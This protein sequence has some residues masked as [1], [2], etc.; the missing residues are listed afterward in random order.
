MSESLFLYFDSK[1]YIQLTEDDKALIQ[2]K[3]KP[4]KLRKKQYFLQEGIYIYTWDCSTKGFSRMYSVYDKGHEFILRCGMESWWI[5]DFE[6]Y[7]LF[8]LSN[9]HIAMLEMR[10]YW[11]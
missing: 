9:F 7:N 11:P 2:D 3:F 8:T 10:N 1:S 4:R 5:G 6:S